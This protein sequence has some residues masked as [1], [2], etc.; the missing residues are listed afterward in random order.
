M[1]REMKGF[2]SIKFDQNTTFTVD[3]PEIPSFVT[4]ELAAERFLKDSLMRSIFN[5]IE[6]KIEWKYD[7]IK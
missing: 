3:F 1:T 7:P 5:Q 4:S 6:N 2:A